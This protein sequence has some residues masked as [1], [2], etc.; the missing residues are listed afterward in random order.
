MSPKAPAAP[1]TVA[2]VLYHVPRGS[3]CSMSQFIAGRN[4]EAPLRAWTG[5]RPLQQWSQHQGRLSAAIKCG[6]GILAR[7]PPY[8]LADRSTRTSIL[9]VGA[10]TAELRAL[11]GQSPIGHSP[12]EHNKY[13]S[14]ICSAEC[15]SKYPCV[16][17]AVASDENLGKH[18]SRNVGRGG[19]TSRIESSGHTGLDP[20]ALCAIR[21]PNS[22]RD[23]NSA[24]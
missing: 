5:A 9:P 21:D 17:R 2:C 18:C 16:L 22:R 23:C 3:R 7:I 11:G 19:Q 14:S 10:H 24:I 20:H 6:A 8:P 12:R 1:G 4:S 15:E 13:G